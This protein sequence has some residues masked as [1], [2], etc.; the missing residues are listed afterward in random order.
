MDDIS[1]TAIAEYLLP[2]LKRENFA[3]FRAIGFSF[4][5][6]VL[7]EMLK[8]FKFLEISQAVVWSSPLLG[9]HGINPLCRYLANIYLRTSKDVLELVHKDKLLE[10]VLLTRGVKV[11]DPVWF[12]KYLDIFKSY[13]ST[14]MEKDTRCL[15]IYDPQD[16][17]VS[18]KNA[19][20]LRDNFSPEF[21]TL[22][23]IIGAG[24][25]GTKDGWV[26]AL[27]AIKNHLQA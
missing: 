1:V 4:G 5:G 7:L 24:H 9:Y 21:Y 3:G 14:Y 2:L 10:K 17:L 25:F 18:I 11:F 23:E 12:K 26:K 15:F 22:A 6:L 19:K 13:Q 20:Y 27:S 16:I 8:N